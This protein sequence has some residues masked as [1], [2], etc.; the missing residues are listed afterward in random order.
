MSA[1]MPGYDFIL[2]KERRLQ[3]IATKGKVTV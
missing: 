2:I 3:T 1:T